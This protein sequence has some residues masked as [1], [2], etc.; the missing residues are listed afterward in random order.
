VAQTFP[1][2]L[3]LVG[4]LLLTPVFDE[5]TNQPRAKAFFVMFDGP[6]AGGLLHPLDAEIEAQAVAAFEEQ[7]GLSLTL[8]S[9]PV[10]MLFITTE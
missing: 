6:P 2:F 4:E 1:E 9:R 5:V 7:T 10:E 8:E 3:E